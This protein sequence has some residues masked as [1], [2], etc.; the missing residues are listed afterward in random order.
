MSSSNCKL[1]GNICES[2]QDSQKFRERSFILIY[3]FYKES[4]SSDTNSVQENKK[5]KSN[6]KMLSAHVATSMKSR[7]C[8]LF[9]FPQP[10][11]SWKLRRWI[12]TTHE[13]LEAP[14]L[15]CH[16]VDYSMWVSGGWG[17]REGG[18]GLC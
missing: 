14:E 3:L 2:P 6:F 15:L 18:G 13:L 9:C 7:L 16:M 11:E 1:L 12:C 17:R 5:K 10:E 4:K 8:R